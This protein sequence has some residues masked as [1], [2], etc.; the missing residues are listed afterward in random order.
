MHL[1]EKDDSFSFSSSAHVESESART[2]SG[3]EVWSSERK[4]AGR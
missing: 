1:I 2:V 4:K 3:S